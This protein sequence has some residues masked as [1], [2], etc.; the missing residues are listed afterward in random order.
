MP[1]GKPGSLGKLI[2]I[3]TVMAMKVR[4]KLKAGLPSGPC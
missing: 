1:G 3:T 4:T 2:D